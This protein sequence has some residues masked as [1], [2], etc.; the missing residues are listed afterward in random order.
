MV[1]KRNAALPPEK[2]L[3]KIET[4]QSIFQI[5]KDDDDDDEED[6]VMKMIRRVPPLHQC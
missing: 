1:S 2:S 5:G 4:V 6:K 3:W